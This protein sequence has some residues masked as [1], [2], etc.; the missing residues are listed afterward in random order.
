[1]ILYNISVGMSLKN[2]VPVKLCSLYK[3]CVCYI[4]GYFKSEGE[5]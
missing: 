5:Y 2:P 4:A 3:H 1:M